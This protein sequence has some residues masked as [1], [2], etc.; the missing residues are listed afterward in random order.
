MKQLGYALI[1]CGFLVAALVSVLEQ[2]TVPWGY[3]AVALAGGAGGVALVRVAER[4]HSRRDDK[5]AAGMQDIKESLQ[6]VVQNLGGLAEQRDGRDC[7]GVRQFIDEHLSQHLSRFVQAR[8]VLA[9][10]YGLSA[11]AEIMSHF[12]AGER[13]LNRIWSACADGYLDEA[14]VYLDKASDQFTLALEKVNKLP[15]PAGR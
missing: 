3:F 10:L 5:L 11:Y 6:Q 15:G 9:H 12:A 4:R 8:R 1:T 2:R 14:S 13:Y 7:Y